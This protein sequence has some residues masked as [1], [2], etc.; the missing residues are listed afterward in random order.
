MSVSHLSNGPVG[1]SLSKSAV[2]SPRSRAEICVNTYALVSW[3]T[4]GRILQM[5]N[6]LG[7]KFISYLIYGLLF[8][9]FIVMPECSSTGNAAELRI[10]YPTANA[11]VRGPITFTVDALGVKGI[12]SVSYLLNGK[13]LYNN[14]EPAMPVDSAPY[15]Y[16]WHTA[17]V[18]DSFDTIQA[19]AEDASG[20]IIQKSAAV[21]FQIAN[22]GTTLRLLSPDTAQTL[23]G[24]V[25]WS[26]ET[27]HG[28]KSG[29]GHRK[30]YIWET[31]IDGKQSEVTFSSNPQPSFTV[32]TT[33]LR[34]GTHELFCA[35]LIETGED[36][37]PYVGMS[38]VMINVDNGR[39]PM[40][41]RSNYKD[42]YLTPSASVPLSPKLIYTNGDQV[43]VEGVY[44]T[45]NPSVASVDDNGIVTGI[46]PGLTTVII[47]SGGFAT[48][49]NVTVNRSKEFP[50]FS[51]DGQIL[52]A[53]DPNHSIFL[54]TPF[55]LDD[56]QL[57]STPQL[58]SAV[59]QAGINALTTGM[60][61][62]PADS[63]IKDFSQWKDSVDE[64]LNRISKVAAQYNL[65]IFLIGD[66]I[67]RTP[68]ELFNSVKDPGSAKKIQYVFNWAKNNGRVIGVD[69]VDEVDILWGSTPMPTDGRWL[70]V[71]PPLPNGAFTTLLNIINGVPGRPKISWPVAGG[72]DILAVK[73]WLGNPNFSEFSTVYWQP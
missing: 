39:A 70:S 53:Y 31:F 56:S 32:D 69:M 50:H 46:N 12:A 35:L 23:K 60:Y 68:Q 51:R 2:S 66:D 3:D 59:Q 34:N 4:P 26:L 49:V 30:T 18:W 11:R 14:G 43:T 55:W 42:L 73:N 6:R 40:E 28:L 67:A 16:T 17:N 47:N 15:S 62:N 72:A 71:R 7:N 58:V 41:L 24:I 52:T 20:N 65:S 1:L 13:T 5:L 37:F 9:I 44:K 54:R 22:N 45:S 27:D 19:V 33:K 29:R 38:Q 48:N 8:G 36:D 64:L 61:Y 21:P 25:S 57:A 63:G 10:T